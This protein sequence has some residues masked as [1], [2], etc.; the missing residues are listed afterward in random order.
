MR[1]ANL[2]SAL[3]L[4]VAGAGLGVLSLTIVGVS[5]PV[6]GGL[7]LRAC[8]DNVGGLRSR[9]PVFVRGVQVGRVSKIEFDADFRPCAWL[10][11][12]AD[13]EL[14]DD[15]SAAILTRG[16]LGDRCVDLDPGGSEQ[17]LQHGDEI[18]YTQGAL[19][20]ERLI[21]RFLLELESDDP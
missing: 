17:L 15:T 8:F 12:D 2:A 13:L 3:V 6:Y 7:S 5:P 16:L 11:V 21:G 18:L 1:P 4:L 19:V 9:D 10:N 20:L 14:A